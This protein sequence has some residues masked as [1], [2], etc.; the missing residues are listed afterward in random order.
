[1]D[2]GL[3]VDLFLAGRSRESADRAK[4]QWAG[5]EQA[6]FLECD[7]TSPASLA[8][9]LDEADLVIHC[10]GPFQKRATCEVLEAAILAK[11][12]YIDVCDDMAFA[13]KAKKLHERAKAAGVPAITTTGIYPGVSNI[14]A[15]QMIAV[16]QA[17]ARKSTNEDGTPIPI[18]QP[19]KLSYH[20]F[21][22]GSGGAGP[23]ILSTSFLL[24]GEQ[25]TAYKDGAAVTLPPASYRQV[26]D[27]GSGVGSR[28][29]FLYNLP[30][31]HSAFETMNIPTV[32]ARFGT[33]PGVF[34]TGMQL[35]AKLAPKGFLQNEFNVKPLVALATPFVKLADKFVGE[36]C[37]MKVCL[38]M[39]D[40]SAPTGVYVHKELSKCVG[41]STAAFAMSVLEGGTQPGVWY[42][43]EGGAV[44]PEDRALLL[45]RASKG[46]IKFVL[47]KALWSVESTPMQLGFGFYTEK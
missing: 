15:A 41:L 18:P 34:N 33:S 6:V 11:V 25:V 7:I 13:K 35:I 1:M 40:G 21:T 30:E 22:A 12:P 8:N 45:E 32:S 26:V 39:D 5:L 29:V 43:E 3:A 14:M 16:H 2:G 17:A 9:A 10:A 20:Y 47:N 19:K 36:K 46:T 4:S 37:A 31:T 42:P 27:F 44:A 28:E 38:E 24:C 23:T